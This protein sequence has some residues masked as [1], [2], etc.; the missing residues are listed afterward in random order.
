MI[1]KV[2]AS[3]LFGNIERS[4]DFINSVLGRPVIEGDRK[5][6]GMIT[7]YDDKTDTFNLDIDDE[8]KERL[9]SN[10]KRS[11]EIVEIIT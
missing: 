5:Q 3:S 2:R 6:I 10:E 9:M 4:Y 1:V 7:Y 8:Y 11:C